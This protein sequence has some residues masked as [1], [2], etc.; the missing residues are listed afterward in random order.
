MEPSMTTPEELGFIRPV[1]TDYIR[2]GDDAI[3]QNA[4]AT[5]AMYDALYK[6]ISDKAFMR[7]IITMDQ[8]IQEDYYGSSMAGVWRCM[9]GTV[10]ASL[11]GLPQ[12]LIDNP[13]LFDLTVKPVGEGV[14]LKIETYDVWGDAE[15]KC[16]SAPSTGTGWSRWKKTVFTEDLP[17]GGESAGGSGFKTLPLILTAGG[18]GGEA[19]APLTA[20]VEY[21]VSLSPSIYVSR[22]R[23][24]IRDGNPRWGTSTAQQIS[25]SNISMGGVAKL[26]SMTTRSDGEISFSPWMTGN[27]GNLK[28]DYT[29]QQQPR[30]QTAG[31]RLNGARRT[32]MP[33][34][35]WLEVE[36]P[37]NTAAVGI[38]GDSNSVGVNTTIP[39]HDAWI[40]QY[41]RRMGFFPVIY[42]HSGDAMQSS[43]DP[44]HYKWNRWNHLDRPDM[45]IHANGANDIPST[46]GGATLAQM[47]EWARAEWA[48][49]DEKVS[50]N[51]HGVVIKSRASGINNTLRLAYNSWIKS[52]PDPLRDWQDI[53]SPVTTGDSGGTL[54][55]YLSSD[56]IHMNTA[57]QA[58]I[59]NSPLKV[60][61]VRTG[62]VFDQTAGRTVK[63]WDYLNQ[64]EQIIY[65]DTGSRDISA[66]IPDRISGEM[67]ISREGGTV[68]LVINDLIVAEQGTTWVYWVGL[69]PTGF[70]YGALG[71]GYMPLSPNASSDSAGGTRIDRFG[72]FYIYNMA[73]GKRARGIISWRTSDPWPTVL[74]GVAA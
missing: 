24:A 42:G 23:F 69:I 60:M 73:G 28:F 5:A 48:V 67:R 45:V 3:S 31:G 47:K 30:Y 19:L 15:Y 41:C 25:L 16:T 10:C 37:A 74:P 57:G 9:S 33:F 52:L 18:G 21:D 13:V 2:D 68:T 62:L 32:Q 39:I 40:S 54:P 46:E 36:I 56:G 72:N 55:Q 26:S 14:I 63:A 50:K 51:K 43:G 59:A 29:A 65:G 44:N 27:F 22:Y 64:R 6:R 34:E 7:G 70:R 4:G 12:D 58:A 38:V 11:D 35:L 17:E 71:Y 53:A 49:T 20:N 1:G 61:T 66:L 8:N